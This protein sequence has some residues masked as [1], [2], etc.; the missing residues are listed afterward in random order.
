MPAVCRA[1]AQ[2]SI[3][4]NILSLPKQLPPNDKASLTAEVPSSDAPELYN[5]PEDPG[6]PDS[7]ALSRPSSSQIP[8]SVRSSNIGF[9]ARKLQRV[10]L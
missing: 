3:G 1:L 2:H 6:R 7:N 9:K 10:V 4:L 5:A 8:S